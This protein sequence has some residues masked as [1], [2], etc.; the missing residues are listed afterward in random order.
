MARICFDNVTKRYGNVV[1]VDGLDLEIRD[2]EFVVL[3][4]PSG[5]GKTTTLNMI[6]GLEELT[7]G[8]IYFDDQI[9]NFNMMSCCSIYFDTARSSITFYGICI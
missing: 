4:G 9:V 5:C 7:E 3:L 1:A 8:D 2:K 6:A